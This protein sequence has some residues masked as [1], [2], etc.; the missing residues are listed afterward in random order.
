[1]STLQVA[2]FPRHPDVLPLSAYEMAPS[3]GERCKGTEG[4]D[5]ANALL[6]IGYLH[7]TAMVKWGYAPPDQSG[8][9]QN[10]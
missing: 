8:I 6:G 10:L 9:H 5:D 7:F 2:E 1:M 3:Y 4:I